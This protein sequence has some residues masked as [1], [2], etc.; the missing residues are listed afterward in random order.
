MTKQG[1]EEYLYAVYGRKNG[2]DDGCIEFET[3]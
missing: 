1:F 3:M 2:T